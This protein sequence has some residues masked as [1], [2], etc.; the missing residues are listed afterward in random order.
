ILNPAIG[1]Q[2]P[3]SSF[4]EYSPYRGIF[5]PEHPGRKAAQLFLLH[6]CDLRA[7]AARV[8]EKEPLERA[9]DFHRCVRHLL[10]VVPLD[11]RAVALGETGTPGP[12]HGIRAGTR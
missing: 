5:G 10:N 3:R 8:L 11:R 6:E 4:S 12:T 2:P 7:E 1:H 9:A